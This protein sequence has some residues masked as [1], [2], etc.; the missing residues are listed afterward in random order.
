MYKGN[1]TT[2]EF[3]LPPG[4]DGHTVW[5]AGGPSAVRLR[6][7]EAYRAENGVVIFGTAPPEGITVT[8]T[9]PESAGR[10]RACTVIYPDGR[11]EEIS[12]DP[13]ALLI[14]ARTELREARTMLREARAAA[15]EAKILAGNYERVARETLSARL[16][17]Y[18]EAVD[19]SV[20]H[21]AA[22]ARDEINDSIDRKLIEIRKKHKEVTDARDEC[23][24]IAA[25]AKREFGEL[26]SGA[27]EKIRSELSSA[28]EAADKISRMKDECAGYVRQAEAA[29]GTAG[30][31]MFRRFETAAQNELEAL[32]SIRSSLEGEVRTILGEA[33]SAV[34][35][36]V[37]EIRRT[38][39]EVNRTARSVSRTH[40]EAADGRIRT[41][42]RTERD[43][44]V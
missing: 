2:K 26:F 32:R 1:G 30:A 8:F 44:G 10:T 35:G 9:E 31:E 15:D 39:D 7:N 29:A 18:R 19:E 33:K 14:E 24:D 5:W 12:D 13:A 3:P 41:E 34:S 25:G 11:I 28:A 43:G 37:D 21:A 6:E 16:D 42:R 36:G 27:L 4:A 17:K 23:G 40:R 22:L 20:T 38:R